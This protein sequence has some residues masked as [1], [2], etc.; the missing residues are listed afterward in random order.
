MQEIKSYKDLNE[1]S[2]EI[3]LNFKPLGKYDKA[4]IE[5][6]QKL[7][8]NIKKA[9]ALLPEK[10]QK[11]L[12]LKYIQNLTNDLIAKKLEKTRDEVEE[13][14]SKSIEVIKEKIKSGQLNEKQLNLKEQEA[15]KREFAGQRPQEALAT[16]ARTQIITFF[17]IANITI[18]IFLIGGVIF[19]AGKILE[20][21]VVN[22]LLKGTGFFIKESI[23]KK[24][25]G[26]GISVGSRR[27]ITIDPKNIKISGST[28]LLELARKWENAFSV[29]YPKYEVSLISSDSDA[30]IRS[31]ING[32]IDIAN[33]SRPL[34]FTD[35]KRADKFGVELEE[36]RVALDAL[37]VLVNK[38]NPIEELDID[39]LEA[40]FSGEIRN[41]KLI[42]GEPV[43]I[44]TFARELGSG[45]NNFVINRILQ[46][47]E[48]PNI[49]VRKNSN[50]EIFEAVS[51]NEGAIGFINS[52]NYPWE[53]ENIKYVKI[54]NFPNS[55]SFSP[56][57]GKKLNEHAIRYGDYPLTHY[58]YLITTADSPQKIK[59][60]VNWVL[61]PKG[62]EVVEYSGLVSL[63]SED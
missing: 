28:S 22:N 3:I 25:A 41:W 40:I 12:E 20:L 57:Q 44:I 21:E 43:P 19:F 18:L 13:I 51:S 15:R 53:S 38:N 2:I 55:L 42:S 29:E 9:I 14:I 36:Y 60:F 30:G 34:S 8:S 50:K 37:I 47:D 33:S 35:R 59:D 46:G 6:I 5:E 48:F 23:G 11:V 62:Q 54:K 27:V 49:T 45:T 24:T 4:A 10:N 1:K 17:R 61:S 52:T 7:K 39:E 58:L 16:D 56:F 26:S 32:S 63:Y 31:L